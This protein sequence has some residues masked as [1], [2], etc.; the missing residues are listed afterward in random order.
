MSDYFQKLA[1]EQFWIA[2]HG[3]MYELHTWAH[4]KTQGE[5]KHGPFKG[6]SMIRD[7]SWNSGDLS[8]KL[9][10]CYEQEL[11]PIIEYWINNLNGA[12][13][14]NVG[15]AEGFYAV[16][17]AVKMPSSRV[18]AFDTDEKAQ[19][20]CLKNAAQNGVESRVSVQG[21]CNSLA[22]E[23]VI[24]SSKI[25]PLIV[26]DCE[27]QEI[28]ILN[29]FIAPSLSRAEILVE[30]HDFENP[31]ITPTLTERFESTH[32]ISF[33]KEHGRNPHAIPELDE[34][35]SVEK[36]LACVEA[37][38][39]TMHWMHMTPKTQGPR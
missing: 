11:Y 39:E 2:Y 28:N 33:I 7:P 31:K 34:F 24:N 8:Q 29:Q 30:C 12:D 23:E 22:L 26:M 27:G 5:I 18:Y 38:P 4:W 10:G 16:G 14:V 36:Y 6:V 3:K 9:F 21:V 1:H 13:I 20:A 32:N 19:E 37:R 17:L 15:C 35:G 25:A